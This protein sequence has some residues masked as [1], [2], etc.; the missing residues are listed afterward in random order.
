MIA[1]EVKRDVSLEPALLPWTIQDDCA[2]DDDA[3]P[4]K[5]ATIT[6]P[7]IIQEHRRATLEELHILLRLRALQ[8]TTLRLR[9]LQ[10]TA[11]LAQGLNEVAQV[12]LQLTTLGLRVLQLTARLA[13]GLDEVAQVHYDLRLSLTDTLTTIAREEHIARVQVDMDVWRGLPLM[14][15]K[16]VAPV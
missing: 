12:A 1:A 7:P 9:V 10:L 13:P 8:L 16:G 6:I 14:I 4:A 15:G 3:L 2:V 11:L 5:R